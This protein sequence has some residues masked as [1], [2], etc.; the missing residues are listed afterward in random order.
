MQAFLLCGLVVFP[1]KLRFG[2]V[3]V[4]AWAKMFG[5]FVIGRSDGGFRLGGCRWPMQPMVP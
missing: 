3:S 2:A 5:R 1:K 4:F